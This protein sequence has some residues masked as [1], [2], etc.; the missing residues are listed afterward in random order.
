MLPD[1]L[2]EEYEKYFKVDI[3]S[4]EGRLIKAAD[5]ISHSNPGQACA[6]SAK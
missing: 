4:D 5:K 2:R 3:S 1:F 6:R